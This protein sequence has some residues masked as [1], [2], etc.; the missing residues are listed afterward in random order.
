MDVH[1]ISGQVTQE[2]FPDL[3]ASTS[4]PALLREYEAE[5]LLRAAMRSDMGTFAGFETLV[6]ATAVCKTGTSTEIPIEALTKILSEAEVLL[7]RG[8]RDE[9]MMLNWL[10][11][12]RGLRPAW[13]SGPLYNE[14]LMPFSSRLED[15]LGLS[16]QQAFSEVQRLADSKTDPTAISEE[17]RSVSDQ[18]SR[19]L[20]SISR[21]SDLWDCGLVDVGRSRLTLTY[22][23]ADVTYRHLCARLQASDPK[24]GTKKGKSLE[25]VVWRR[26]VRLSPNWSWYQGYFVDSGGERDL[27]GFGT[28]AGLAIESKSYKFRES[29]SEWSKLNARRDAEPIVEAV[30]Q[31]QAGLQMLRDG[32]RILTTPMRGKPASTIK[33]KPK[34]IWHGIVVSDEIYTPYVR[35]CYDSFAPPTKLGKGDWHGAETWVASILDLE[36]LVQSAGTT[37]LV[38]DY[39]KWLRARKN[40]RFTDE[41]ESWL[42]YGTEPILPA[43]TR[44]NVNFIGRGYNWSEAR[45]AGLQRYRPPWLLRRDLVSKL[46]SMDRTVQAMQVVKQDRLRATNVSRKRL[47]ALHPRRS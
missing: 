1:D 4:L 39:L 33:V 46:D 22:K 21:P 9:T 23:I 13:F 37:S 19:P 16:A 32:G 31:V 14:L 34:R 28:K 36:F 17:F 8:P 42:L 27:I 11:T 41:P 15:T 43:A 26:L 40:L 38:L 45:S 47:E 6:A 24:F 7:R 30:A 3:V 18:L 10:R 35:A 44:L 5:A 12:I 25:R 2:S 29:S 20:E